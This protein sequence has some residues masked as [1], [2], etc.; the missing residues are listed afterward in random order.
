MPPKPYSTPSILPA[1]RS[2]RA[3]ACWRTRPAARR[4]RASRSAGGRR[5]GGRGG[6][7]VRRASRRKSARRS[8]A[9]SPEEA[10]A[11]AG[12][13]RRVP[14][15]FVDGQER[16]RIDPRASTIARLSLKR[17]GD[18]RGPVAAPGGEIRSRSTPYGGAP[19]GQREQ[20]RVFSSSSSP[21]NRPLGAAPAAGSACG[22][23]RRTARRARPRALLAAR[24]A[25]WRIGEGRPGWRPDG[26]NSRSPCFSFSGAIGLL[27][28]LSRTPADQTPATRGAA[29]APVP[30]PSLR[31]A[32]A[33]PAPSSSR[34]VR[35][36]ADS[37]P[38]GKAEAGSPIHPRP[39]H[40]APTL[41][42]PRHS[43]KPRRPRPAP[44]PNPPHSAGH[45]AFSRNGRRPRQA[46]RRVSASTIVR[47][48]PARQTPLD[49]V[50]TLRRP[51]GR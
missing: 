15:A 36:A 21:E 35:P 29:A 6:E 26:A 34:D 43:R 1:S 31:H 3:W 5:A 50:R 27:L 12:T 32:D 49:A 18:D 24:R 2:S 46:A 23:N 4:F 7:T 39:A 19:E 44:A 48:S 41:P 9:V 47:P 11:G 25:A 13:L 42:L 40:R 38:C 16:A 20:A 30:E 37:G 22:G 28:Y 33:H 8:S 10:R 14:R 17:R 45:A 51:D